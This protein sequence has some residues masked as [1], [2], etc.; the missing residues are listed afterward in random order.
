MDRDEKR[1]IRC[2]A[3]EPEIVRAVLAAGWTEKTDTS[4]GAQDLDYLISLGQCYRLFDDSG[5]TLAAYILKINGPE[6][7]IALGA[8]RAD[9]DLTA[10]GLAL[11]EAQGREFDS[12]GFK[13]RRRG[14]VKK[15]GKHGYRVDACN[16]G[17]YTLRKRIK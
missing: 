7:W 5:E 1:V 8:G 3:C 12:I 10:V 17:I 9:I 6:L 15:A 11:I 14:L 13:T 2:K 16:D 4:N